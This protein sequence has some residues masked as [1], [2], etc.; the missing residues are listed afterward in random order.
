MLSEEHIDQ[1]NARGRP[2]AARAL[3]KSIDPYTDESVTCQICK[4]PYYC[5]DAEG[6][7]ESPKITPC[8]HIF[9]SLCIRIWITRERSFACPVCRFRLQFRVCEHA[10][11]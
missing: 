3:A 9:G 8:G 7:T 6:N 10:I 2:E 11:M 1:L 4:T 5:F